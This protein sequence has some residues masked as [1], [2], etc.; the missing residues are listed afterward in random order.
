V[1]DRIERVLHDPAVARD[2]KPGETEDD[3]DGDGP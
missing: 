2:L 1:A 3:E